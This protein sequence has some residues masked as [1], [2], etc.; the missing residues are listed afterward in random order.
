MSAIVDDGPTGFD[1]LFEDHTVRC[2]NWQVD[3][4]VCGRDCGVTVR[5]SALTSG[6]W[7]GS[8]CDAGWFVT[9]HGRGDHRHLTPFCCITCFRRW[10]A[11]TS[12]QGTDVP[13]R[14]GSP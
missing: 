12:P 14:R 6:S 4:E 2:A 9:I 3:P 10:A 8:V 7:V 5:R 1:D 11:R 13:T